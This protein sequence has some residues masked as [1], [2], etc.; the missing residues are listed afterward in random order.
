[1]K[2]TYLLFLAT[3]LFCTNGFSQEMKNR[4]Q[5]KALKTAFITTELDLSTA[6][7]E[8]FWPIYNQFDARFFELR[9]KKMRSLHQ[10]I[11][12]NSA[13]LSEKEATQLLNDLE[14][15]EEELFQL[16][17]KLNA[18]LKGIIGSVKIIKLKK[19][20]DDF[21]RKLLR[22]YRANRGNKN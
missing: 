11:E 21:N 12:K 14:A 15:T 3:V 19:A 5:I 10:T 9:N 13:T 8:K 6:E 20:E 18:D 16:R 7:A 1:M 4:D 2:S 17:K 22:Q